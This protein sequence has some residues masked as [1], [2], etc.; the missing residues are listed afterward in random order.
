MSFARFSEGDVYVYLNV[1]GYFE[2]CACALLGPLLT[3]GCVTVETSAEMLAHLESHR[4]VGHDV[5]EDC[6]EE[7][8]SDAEANDRRAAEL[9]E[10]G[11]RRG[12]EPPLVM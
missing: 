4:A 10:E 7:L 9:R 1:D 6:L 8:R 5:P 11:R 2:C 12:K 3:G